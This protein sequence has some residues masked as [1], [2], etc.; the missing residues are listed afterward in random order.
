[1][2][3]GLP[4]YYRM[5]NSKKG[6]NYFIIDRNTGEKVDECNEM[7]EAELKVKKLNKKDRE[8]KGLETLEEIEVSSTYYSTRNR[9]PEPIVPMVVYK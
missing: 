9:D 7:N 6:P 5:W 4:R 1:M 8:E 3:R 2:I